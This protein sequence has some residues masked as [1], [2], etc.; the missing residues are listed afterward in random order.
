MLIRCIEREKGSAKKLA[1]REGKE[2]EIK[3]AC[4]CVAEKCIQITCM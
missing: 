2:R 1:C 4:G 3:H